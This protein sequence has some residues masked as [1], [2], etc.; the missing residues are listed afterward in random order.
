ML[1]LE[2]PHTHQPID[3]IISRQVQA[4]I[5]QLSLVRNIGEIV[6]GARNDDGFVDIGLLVL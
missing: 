3:P 4:A 6:H 2:L 5:G 1:E